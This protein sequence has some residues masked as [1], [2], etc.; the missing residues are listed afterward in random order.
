[1]ASFST[2]SDDAEHD[3]IR[4]VFDQSTVS[5]SWF[6]AIR[7]GSRVRPSGA[8][9]G[10]FKNRYLTSPEGFQ[11]FANRNVQKASVLVA[12]VLNAST[13]DEYRA[14]VRHLD[15]LSDL[16]CRVLDLCDFVRMTHPDP[17]FQAA[18]T[19]AW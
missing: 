15:R 1:R 14:V 10:L 5:K 3:I 18:A 13:V 16:L 11:L 9:A 6:S 12:K 8:N 17:K 7:P 4:E 19:D 2:A